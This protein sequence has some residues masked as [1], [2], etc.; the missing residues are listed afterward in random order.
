M[1]NKEMIEIFDKCLN[2]EYQNEE[3]QPIMEDIYDI[4]DSY[5]DEYVLLDIEIPDELKINIIKL[6][7]PLFKRI[8]DGNNAQMFHKILKELIHG[9]DHAINLELIAPTFILLLNPIEFCKGNQRGS[10]GSITRF[11]EE[12]KYY[13]FYRENSNYLYFDY[14]SKYFDCCMK[15]NVK[16]NS[17]GILAI[18]YFLENNLDCDKFTRVLDYI[19]SKSEELIT[20]TTLNYDNTKKEQL[21]N[22][23]MEKILSEIDNDYIVIT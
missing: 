17:F 2:K 16:R 9:K 3:L 21:L 1:T 13:D 8:I 10:I 12:V 7:F 23:I 19:F 22:A 6:F 18:Y 14:L 5:F 11:F 15:Y 20:Y 4:F